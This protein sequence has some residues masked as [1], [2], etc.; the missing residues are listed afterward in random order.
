MTQWQWWCAARADVWTWTWKPY[1][2][3]W[4]I[5]ALAWLCLMVLN[6]PSRL[7]SDALTHARQSPWSRASMMLGLLL[8]W[9]ALDWPVG[10]LGTGYLAWVHAV[11]FVVLAMLAPTLLLGGIG[12]VGRHRLALYRQ[13]MPGAQ[14]LQVMTRPRV[15][16]G[17][18]SAVMVGSHLPPVADALMASATGAFVL[19]MS[20]LVSGLGFAWPL[21]MPRPGEAPMSPLLRIGYLF[22]GTIAHVFIGMWLL[23]ADYPL[24]A[25]YELAP[26]IGTLSPRMDQQVA[27][28]VMLLLGT[29]LVVV[30]IGL[31]F[32]A[33]GAEA[34][35]DPAG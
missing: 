35:D 30:A 19:D 11:Q 24:Y 23:V 9:S 14:A 32:R 1:P 29:P 17:L 34:D 18:F 33:L 10:A 26:P 28:G 2:G 3:V 4:M 20:W 13:P 15:A 8:L 27:G 31:Q 16:M 6:R 12:S 25:T 21:I 22:A 5:V 7:S